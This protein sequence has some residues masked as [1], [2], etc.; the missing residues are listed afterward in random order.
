LIVHLGP[1]VPLAIIQLADF[2]TDLFVIDSM[3]WR[4]A[5][6]YSQHFVP[7]WMGAS[8]ICVSALMTDFEAICEGLWE[9]QYVFIKLS[10][11][12][13]FMLL[14]PFNLHLIYLGVLYASAEAA[15]NKGRAGALH[16]LFLR[17]KLV[18]ASIEAAPLA[19]VTC[20]A[21][22]NEVDGDLATC[23]QCRDMVLYSTSVVLSLLSMSCKPPPS[24]LP[25]LVRRLRCTNHV[26]TF[27][28]AQTASGAT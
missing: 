16:H 2:M 1:V 23:Q 3:G 17:S 22:L 24:R 15:G 25:C 27:G 9:G 10:Q 4:S 12:V 14:V 18:E 11:R 21:L 8:F 5:S 7:A 13:I 20:V 19:L 6:A 26:S 28:A